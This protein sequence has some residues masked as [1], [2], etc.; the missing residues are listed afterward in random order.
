MTAI[1]I[2]LFLWGI[3]SIFS[4]H[5]AVEKGIRKEP[6]ELK[7]A[8]YIIIL[9]AAAFII[10]IVCAC[11]YKGHASDMACFD[12]WSNMI[13][14]DGF[15]NFYASDAFTDYPPG[16]MYV[17]YV[18]GAIKDWLSPGDTVK[19]LILKMPAIIC[20]IAAG[21]FIYKLAARKFTSAAA[22]VI[23]GLYMLNPATIVDSSLWGQVDSIYTLGLIALVY[24]SANKK[25]IPAY[26]VFAVCIFIKPQSLILTPIVIYGIIDTVF[27]PKFDKEAFLKNL[28]LGLCAIG[29]MVVMA[30]PFGINHVVEQYTSTLASY[31]YMTINAFN[32][33]GAL[34]KNWVGV[35]TGATMFGYAMIVLTVAYTTYVFIKS[36]NPAKYYYIGA[37]LTFMTYVLS[38]KMHERYAFAAMIMLLAAYIVHPKRESM[39]LYVAMTLMQFFNVAWILF[40]YSK[41]MNVYYKSPVVRIGSVVNI[42]ILIY[43][44]YLAQKEYVGYSSVNETVKPQSVIP[45]QKNTKQRKKH[46]VEKSKVFARITAI[47]LVAMI[48]ITA[49]YSV[50]AV[51]DLGNRYSPES[52]FS[53]GEAQ[54]IQIDL[55][56]DTSLSQLSFFN[57]SYEL[58]DNNRKMTIQ[59]RDSRGRSSSIEQKNGSV[60]HWQEVDVKDKTCRYITL[61]TTADKL[62][63]LELGI[64]DAD[65][66]WVYPANASE[67][68][69]LFDEQEMVPERSNFRNSTYFDEIYHA[70]TAYEFVHGL[71][72]Y[73]W[74]HPPL[75][76]VFI[77]LG[78]MLFGMNPF[79]W[80]IAGTV[81]GILMVPVI[82]IFGKKMFGKTWLAAAVCLL[83]TF[84]FMHFAQTRIAT[85]DVY[86]TFFIMLMYLFMYLYYR[87]SFYDT[88]LSKTFVPLGLCGITMG[89][90]IASK[91]T[92]IYASVGLAII[93]FITLHRRYSEYRYAMKNPAGETNGIS[94]RHIIDSF[95]PNALKT[96][97]FCCIFFVVVPLLIYVASYIPYLHTEGAQGLKT[98]IDNQKSMLTY[99]GKTVLGS[100]HPYSS[101]WYEWII[102]K[103]PIW[104]FSGTVS[105]NIK[106]GISAFGNPAVWW[107]GI[108]AFLGCIYFAAVKKSKAAL[109]LII[110]YLAEIVSWIPITRLTFIYHYF[111]SVPFI[112]MMI[113]YCI[114][115][116]YNSVIAADNGNTAGEINA[117]I[118]KRARTV[119][120]ST[121]VYVVIAIV[122]FAM[123]YPVLSGQPVNVDYVKNWLK[124]FDSWVLI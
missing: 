96:I 82:Y 12:G 76:K 69:G 54:S 90:A 85:I 103:R 27:L 79:G 49:V 41:D 84:D 66:N 124:W 3:I 115:E 39:Y 97:G 74:T 75:G 7:N 83:F 37:L 18:L 98:I 80:R 44:I 22:A 59:F 110:G 93:F 58:N 87:T 81:F 19:Y 92:G 51:H 46:R 52:G 99:H 14:K 20:D 102:M 13:Y 56:R 40:I 106:E 72:V 65:G 86:V 23:A 43:M 61:S 95:K 55:G 100:T 63:L 53:L 109:F 114:Y 48:V 17:L 62:T 42:L 116:I 119:I 8:E 47:D 105:S 67:F 50:I 15:A 29:V 16:Y 78:I 11:I 121:A 32:L 35:T 108:P 122:L 26:F 2:V 118:S 89:L 107:V 38:T 6:K 24:L 25:M 70:R 91:W 57:G 60:F 31:P 9:T 28:L 88:K 4:Y 113:V 1:L 101:K 36:K 104:Y 73:E 77:S 33:W 64:K 30:L 120:I 123:F 94:H 21:L 34:G 111:P 45:A 71:G 68:G 112:T 5:F 117:V 10:R